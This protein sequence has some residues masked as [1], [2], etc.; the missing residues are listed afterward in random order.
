MAELCGARS[1]GATIDAGGWKA[2]PRRTV[3]LRESAAEDLLGA[4]PELSEQR[5][6]LERLGF[7]VRS[8]PG[9]LDVIVPHWRR[10]DVAREADLV[11]EVGRI[12]GLDKLPI[13]L[14]SRR[15]ASGRL[16]ARPAA[17]A[18]RGGRAGRLRRLRD[19]RLE[20]R[21]ARP[22][23]SAGAPAGD[24]RRR[25]VALRNPMSEDQSV[26][27][28]TLLG[29]LLDNVRRNRAHGVDDV[30]LWEAGAVYF[31]RGERQDS[32]GRLV[33]SVETAGILRRPERI[34]GLERLPEEHLH[35]GAL[36][37]GRVRPPT[38]GDPGPPTAG[39]YAAK[40]VLEAVLGALRVP[41]TVKPEREPFLHPGRSARVL[42]GADGHE[43]GWLGELHPTVAG[44][45][46]LEGAVAGFELNLDVVLAEAPLVP[47]F[48]D[49]TTFPVVREDVAVVLARDVPAE[50]LIEVVR[51]AG[52][53]LLR[54]AEVFDVYEG[55]QVGEGNR[56]LAIRL[57]FRAAD[58][59]LTDEEVAGLRSKIVAAV[60][61][62]LGGELRG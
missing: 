46:D 53:R 43:A 58:R 44:A 4:A 39:F 15:G 45:W 50:R 14:P 59:T 61:E 7:A 41:W 55:P 11:E 54:R 62:R 19:P 47:D 16:D 20:L 60:R 25:V 24:P 26:M 13:T 1:V 17:A 9:G 5:A 48:E 36:M 34:P 29:S 40:G 31:A 56:S 51:E 37:A 35:L 2:P 23:G 6:I 32:N 42:V 33:P 28:T 8:A 3:H 27:R 52:G 21:V 12:W 18:A 49:L 30:R 38:W 10:G 22:R 57:E